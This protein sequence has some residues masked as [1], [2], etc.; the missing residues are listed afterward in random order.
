M[1]QATS[2]NSTIHE[3]LV[4]VNATVHI[5]F[6]D[7]LGAV[8]IGLIFASIL[9]GIAN[10]QSLIYYQNPANDPKYMKW[11]VMVLWL[12]DAF[13]LALVSHAI[14]GYLVTD[15]GSPTAVTKISW[16]LCVLVF[17][18][19]LS[20]STIALFY[21]YRV[22]I[23]SGMAF[24]IKAF[25]FKSVLEFTE[26]SWLVYIN[27]G[28]S[29]ASDFWCALCLCYYLAKGRTGIRTSNTTLST[30]MLYIISTGLLTS[31]FS[32][33]CLVL[34]AAVPRSYF[35]IG[36]YFCLSELYFNGFLGMLNARNYL[37]EGISQV[38]TSRQ[39]AYRLPQII[40]IGSASSSRHETSFGTVQV[41]PDKTANSVYNV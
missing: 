30:L 14:Y 25:A 23:M 37:R 38:G 4:G 28:L 32:I 27:L 12:L 3:S 24:G 5:R 19:I 39:E 13:H 41:I 35:S 33:C 11:T 22:W 34:A 21:V 29:V 40:N 26:I 8:L 2:T 1:M 17:V 20:D 15:F 7:S 16:S 6:D 36:I 9:F 18:T 31:L 10:V